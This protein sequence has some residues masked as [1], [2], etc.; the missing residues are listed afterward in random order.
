MKKSK[1][2]QLGALLAAMLI[3]SVAFLPIVNAA[4]GQYPLQQM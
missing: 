3:V 2:M 4:E 1:G